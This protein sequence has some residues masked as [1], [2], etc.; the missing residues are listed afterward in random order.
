MTAGARSAVREYRNHDST[1][2]GVPRKQILAMLAGLVRFQGP[3][4]D[5]AHE[6][7]PEFAERWFRRYENP[8][9]APH[10]YSAGARLS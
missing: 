3:H 2:A 5:P 8:Q 10:W 6:T 4:H 7:V 1:Y 9:V